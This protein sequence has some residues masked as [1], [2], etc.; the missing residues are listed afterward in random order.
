MIR[1]KAYWP[2]TGCGQWCQAVGQ[3]TLDRAQYNPNHRLP[4]TWVQEQLIWGQE[5]Q[6]WLL[7]AG[8]CVLRTPAT[9]CLSVDVGSLEKHTCKQPLVCWGWMFLCPPVLVSSS[10][11]RQARRMCKDSEH[12]ARLP[13]EKL[14]RTSSPFLRKRDK[15]EVRMFLME[16]KT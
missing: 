5:S 3:K 14:G 12:V 2:H 9:L 10:P 16:T 15:K 1:S 11:A 4:F 8:S 13:W 6:R 7:R